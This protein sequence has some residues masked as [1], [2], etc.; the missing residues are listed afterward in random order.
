MAG[1]I[2]IVFVPVPVT[3]LL[4]TSIVSNALS[5][6]VFFIVILP[7][8]TSTFSLKVKTIFAVLD[9]FVASSAGVLDDSVGAVV[10]EEGTL[11]P[12]FG[13]CADTNLVLS[14]QFFG[15]FVLV[16][17]LVSK[18]DKSLLYFI[19]PFKKL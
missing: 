14:F 9:T 10:H 6:L 12:Q 18:Q 5:S 1:L 11:R 13:Y 3:L 17:T 15:A 2:S 16:H 7:L 4:V 8:S 19:A